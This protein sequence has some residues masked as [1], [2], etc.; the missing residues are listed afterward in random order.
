MLIFV[1]QSET[2]IGLLSGN[3]SN[4][5]MRVIVNGKQLIIE[6]ICDNSVDSPI[7]LV[8]TEDKNLSTDQVLDLC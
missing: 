6:E 7:N 4:R 1:V 5:K 8:K 2:R 3:D